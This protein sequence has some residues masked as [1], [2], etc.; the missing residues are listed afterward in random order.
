MELGGRL[1]LGQERAGVENKECILS[2]YVFEGTV[3]K[4]RE[5]LRFPLGSCHR[6]QPLLSDWQAV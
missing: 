6:R 1:S 4:Q 5:G 3:D 2:E